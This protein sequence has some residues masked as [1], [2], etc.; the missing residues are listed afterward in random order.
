M[1]REDP[2]LKLRLTEA[3]K[4]AVTEAA[5]TNNRS[6]NSEIVARL[7]NSF[8]ITVDPKA[9]AQ[10][11]EFTED[12]RKRLEL[13]WEEFDAD[14]KR[15]N[16]EFAQVEA[17]RL[18]QRKDIEK[19]RAE[20]LEMLRNERARNREAQRTKEQEIAAREERMFLRGLE[21]KQRAMERRKQIREDEARLREEEN[22]IGTYYDRIRE[23]EKELGDL[24]RK[25][26]GATE[27]P[28]AHSKDS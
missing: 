14:V 26:T 12:L 5:K 27:S 23:R 9:L 3:L 8:E 28:N 7:E 1:G 4:E 19:K 22:R 21:M 6:V 20:L 11:Y 17:L 10:A 16:A 18:Q 13:A 24:I 15:L 2:Q 25:L